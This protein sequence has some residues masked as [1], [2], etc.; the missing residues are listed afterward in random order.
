MKKL[1]PVT[2]LA[3]VSLQFSA[4]GPAVPPP[5]NSPDV[6]RMI[7]I[8]RLVEEEQVQ[9]AAEMILALSLK[10]DTPDWGKYLKLLASGLGDGNLA[11]AVAGWSRLAPK[12]A[13]DLLILPSDPAPVPLVLR[14][15]SREQERYRRYLDNLHHF[16]TAVG[17]KDPHGII[18]GLIP[19][20]YIAD[21]LN[22]LSSKQ[23]SRIVTAPEETRPPYT[24]LLLKNV[25]E[26]YHRDHIQPLLPRLLTAEEHRIL[27]PSAALFFHLMNRLSYSFS[28]PLV[29]P[30]KGNPTRLRTLDQ[31]LPE[32]LLIISEIRANTAAVTCS[33]VFADHKIIS[34][35]EEASIYDY[36][37]LFLLHRLQKQPAGPV[38]LPYLIQFNFL[39]RGFSLSY[40]L[41]AEKIGINRENARAVVRRLHQDILQLEKKGQLDPV[42]RFIHSHRSMDPQLGKI[43]ELLF[44][45]SPESP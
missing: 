32:Q 19:P 34:R 6:A 36:Y 14:Y 20:I 10:A 39:A 45:A 18:P 24:I 17:F 21:R 41:E 42:T 12:P 28:Y 35:E 2:L 30:P 25:L 11:P 40:N 16:L 3:L 43:H 15:H 29:T 37:L 5:Q 23:F 7:Q 4:P 9:K 27:S 26:E 44:H 1:L 33:S 31:V 22:P 38:N 8:A 13:L